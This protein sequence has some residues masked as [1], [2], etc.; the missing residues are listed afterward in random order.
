MTTNETKSSK[1]IKIYPVDT[2][3]KIKGTVFEKNSLVYSCTLN[4]TEIETNKNK[5]YIM[6][7]IKDASEYHLYVRYGRVGENGKTIYKVFQSE[8]SAMHE[9]ATQFKSKTGNSFGAN[10]VKKAGKYFMAQV[11]YEIDEDEIEDTRPKEK[12]ET[13]LD[14][15]QKFLMELFTNKQTMENTLVSMS[16]DP[17]KMPLGKISKSQLDEAQT[18]LTQ[19]KNLLPTTNKDSSQKTE[20]DE[21]CEKDEKPKKRGRPKKKSL[22]TNTDKSNEPDNDET[23]KSAFSVTHTI[24]T[25]KRIVDCNKFTELS[26]NFYTLVPYNCGRNLPPVIDNEKTLGDFV[27]MLDDLKNLEVAIKVTKQGGD[28]LDNVYNSLDAVI[29]P[30][31]KNSEMWNIISTY[32]T[33]THGSTHHKKAELVD[34]Y[35]LS[36]NK[37]PACVQET[38]KKIGNRQLLWHGSRMTNF[39]SI[40]KNGLILNPETLGVFITGK[41]FGS[42]L[43]LASSF[44][45]SFNYC[46]SDTSGGYACLLLCEAALGKQL[47]KTQSDSYLSPAK[48]K[49]AGNYNSTWGKGQ[50]TPSGF[51]N[52]GDMIVPNGKLQKSST[53]TCLIYD[54]YIV[55][56]TNQVSLKYLVIVKEK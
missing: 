9:F 26:S 44:S 32:I 19:I 25:N 37:E 2:L 34:I 41:M 45:K 39:C 51:I 38:L 27:T 12:Q 50:N 53:N 56:D 5:F 13:K 48:L 46:A 54:E 22:D 14:N 35:D 15:R 23:S 55:Y 4:Q 29:K 6:Q 49:V 52:Y 18:I 31:D 21:K 17:K 40:I 20:I 1:A 7:I 43:Y 10:F 30:L 8:S 47:E 36:R 33:N 42:G 24:V 11:Q 16:I 3:C 28:N